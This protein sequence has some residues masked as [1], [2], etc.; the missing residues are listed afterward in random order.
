M[1]ILYLSYEIKT[2]EINFLREIAYNVISNNSADVVYIGNKY[3][4]NKLTSLGLLIRGIIFI[5]SAQYYM[6]NKLK[7]IKNK[8][9]SFVLQDAESVCDFYKKDMEYD[10]FMKH[11]SCLKYIETI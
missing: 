2:R 10:L 7:K 4:I 11:P 5:K 6:V 3:L 1:R 8:G 9:F